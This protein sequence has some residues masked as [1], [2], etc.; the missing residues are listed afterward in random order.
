MKFSPYDWTADDMIGGNPALDFVNTVSGW[1][2][3]PVDRLDG[4]GGFADWVAAAGLLDAHDL[5]RL[6][7]EIADDPK[8]AMKTWRDAKRLRTALHGIFTAAAEGGEADPVDLAFLNDWKIRAARHCSDQAG[9]R[10]FRT[11]VYGR[12][13]SV[14]T[15]SAPDLR[16][17]GRFVAQWPA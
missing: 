8:G 4:P 16:R 12:R 2:D 10:A 9:R 7:A 3:A 11:P 1:R 13:A 5:K 15:R 14:R 17:R 6:T